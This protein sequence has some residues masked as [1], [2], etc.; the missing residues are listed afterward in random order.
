MLGVLVKNFNPRRYAG[1][2][3]DIQKPQ[4]GWFRPPRDDDLTKSAFC[5]RA[6]HLRNE[7]FHSPLGA[8]SDKKSFDAIMKRIED[9]LEGFKSPPDVLQAFQRHKSLQIDD[10]KK[11]SK[12]VVTYAP[13]KKSQIVVERTLIVKETIKYG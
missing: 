4:R 8:F 5:L 6:I 7:V 9:V 2:D 10:V 1:I 12:E 11:M 13:P 3:K